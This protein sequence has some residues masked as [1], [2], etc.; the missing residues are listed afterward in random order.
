MVKK[1]DKLLTFSFLLYLDGTTTGLRR[2]ASYPG[3]FP[4]S[5][6]QVHF[7]PSNGD[8]HEPIQLCNSY[9]PM[10]KL[11]GTKEIV[12]SDKKQDSNTGSPYFNYNNNNNININLNDSINIHNNNDNNQFCGN[13][14]APTRR[15]RYPSSVTSES[16]SNTISVCAESIAAVKVDVGTRHNSINSRT[17]LSLL[18]NSPSGECIRTKAVV[19]TSYITLFYLCQGLPIL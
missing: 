12:L 5:L 11:P 19:G 6:S 1:Q 4:Q 16:N 2:F 10:G 13:F 8:H 17:S 9:D 18:I 7:K 15:Q 3:S 14:L